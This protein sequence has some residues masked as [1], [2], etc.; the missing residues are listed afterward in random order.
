MA[1]GLIKKLSLGTCENTALSSKVGKS[2][3]NLKAILVKRKSE[4]SG[5]VWRDAAT[6][7]TLCE[8]DVQE[9]D[10]FWRYEVGIPKSIACL[11]RI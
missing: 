11:L 5:R 7:K 6:R 3:A 10:L 2:K 4:F 8:S 1:E 9:I